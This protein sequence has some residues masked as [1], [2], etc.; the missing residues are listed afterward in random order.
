[1]ETV[2][3]TYLGILFDLDGVLVDTAKYHYL[4]WKKTA[5]RWGYEL[6]EAANEHLKG[7]SRSDSLKWLLDQAGHQLSDE[8]FADTLHSKNEDYLSYVSLLS[9]DDLLPGALEFL[10][11]AKMHG[12]LMALA[13]ASK[14]A[15]G[16]L[17]KLGIREFFTA[18]ADGNNTMKGKPDP[19]VFLNAA[20]GLNLPADQCFAIED[21]IMGI[22][23]ANTAG[24][25]TIGIGDQDILSEA[26]VVYPSLAAFKIS[27]VITTQLTRP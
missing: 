5:S 20:R 2:R 22:R 3:K 17:E 26:D 18:I 10:E 19:E 23:A 11:N 1:M 7:V 27:D 21:S 13:S 15:I 24:C 9:R 6:T 25:I 16:I 14:N 8:E 12:Y 4:A